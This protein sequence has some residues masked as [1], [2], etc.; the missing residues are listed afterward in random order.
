MSHF[1][2]LGACSRCGGTVV[3][4]HGRDYCL[5][6]TR[7]PGRTSRA[8]ERQVDGRRRR[9]GQHYRRSKAAL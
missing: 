5:S 3:H 8:V 1:R 4:E 9:D 6:C 2:V 7:T